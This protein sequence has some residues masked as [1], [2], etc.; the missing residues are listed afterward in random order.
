MLRCMHAFGKCGP[1]SPAGGGGGGGARP[2]LPRDGPASYISFVASTNVGRGMCMQ[3]PVIAHVL[4][5]TGRL[6]LHS[7]EEWHVS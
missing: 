3:L 2:N 1:C 6:V 7:T 5:S 4:D